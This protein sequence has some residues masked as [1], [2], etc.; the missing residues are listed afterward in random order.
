MAP[1]KKRRRC[2]TCP[3]FIAQNNQIC[4]HC[5][6]QRPVSVSL[7]FHTLIS[8]IFVRIIII[9]FVRI[10][11]KSYTTYYFNIPPSCQSGKTFIKS[12]VLIVQSIHFPAIIRSCK[13]YS[14]T[15]FFT[16]QLFT[17]RFYCPA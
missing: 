16:T 11:Q 10:Y 4:Q 6:M 13:H 8:F 1:K 17:T 7:I 2:A 3:R 15:T 5:F 14:S 12:C 9:N